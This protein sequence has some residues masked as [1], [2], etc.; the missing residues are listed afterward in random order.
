MA[1]DDDKAIEEARTQ[2]EIITI[3]KEKLKFLAGR[4][5]ASLDSHGRDP[6]RDAYAFELRALLRQ[7]A[8]G[9]WTC[10]AFDCNQSYTRKSHMKGHIMTSIDAKHR[11]LKSI[12]SEIRCC[13][14]GDEARDVM[15]IAQQQNRE[16]FEHGEALQLRAMEHPRQQSSGPQKTDSRFTH[17]NQDIQTTIPNAALGEPLTSTPLCRQEAQISRIVEGLSRSRSSSS[18]AEHSIEVAPDVESP[19]SAHLARQKSNFVQHERSS[20]SP[21]Q[22]SQTPARESDHGSLSIGIEENVRDEDRHNKSQK[23]DTDHL[24]YPNVES[25]NAVMKT[26]TH[27]QPAANSKV[28]GS[29]CSSFMNDRATPSVATPTVRSSILEKPYLEEVSSINVTGP[30]GRLVS[31]YHVRD[32][33]TDGI[34]RPNVP[35]SGCQDWHP[36]PHLSYES[37][38]PHA[39]WNA[40]SPHS[41][42]IPPLALMYSGVN[43]GHSKGDFQIPQCLD[44]PPQ[45]ESYPI[46][47]RSCFAISEYYDSSSYTSSDHLTRDTFME[48]MSTHPDYFGRQSYAF[49]QTPTS[50]AVYVKQSPSEE[51]ESYSLSG[52]EGTAIV[53]RTLD[54]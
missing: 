43:M 39:R 52:V 34:T 35:R 3:L 54:E 8:V 45:R 22:G 9:R 12:L 6:Q 50:Q 28:Y 19:T 48:G 17:G 33:I 25:A 41:S 16:H 26:D 51:H 1:S 42:A 15:I 18:D 37:S 53:S 27:F 46:S 30:E 49:D 40:S 38:E 36:M 20:A 2:R 10:P 24:D 7:K 31:P 13:Y 47:G 23:G 11:V 44:Q 29:N 4:E 32:Y 21:S 5:H 14:C